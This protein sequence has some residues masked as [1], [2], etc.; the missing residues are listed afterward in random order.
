[1]S[2]ALDILTYSRAQAHTDSNGISDTNGLAWLNDTLNEFRRELVKRGVDIVPVGAQSIN[3]VAGTGIYSYTA[4]DYFMLKTME[5]NFQD[6]SQG[7]YLQAEQFDVSNLQGQTSF[8]WLRLNQP[9]SQPLFDDRGANF[10]VF[11]TPVTSVTAGVKIMYYQLPTEYATTNSSLA[12]PETLDYRILG[13]GVI[14]RY[15]YYLKDFETGDK[16]KAIFLK[17]IDNLVQ[18]VGRG[19]QQPIRTEPIQDSGWGY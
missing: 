8:D 16:F 15:F 11:P 5:I 1:M 9:T 2:V 3:L 14:A 10:E 17:D 6:S 7:N 12:Y 19:S 18:T 4:S 13:R